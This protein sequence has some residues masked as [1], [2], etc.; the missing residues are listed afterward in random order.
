[1]KRILTILLLA[2]LLV[3]CGE[4]NKTQT[5]SG[6][7]EQN[8]K[9]DKQLRGTPEELAQSAFD[10]FVKNDKQAYKRL[11]AANL[12]EKEWVSL[13]E[14]V[15][16]SRGKLPS[17]V[18]DKSSEELAAKESKNVQEGFERSW[19]DLQDQL[20]KEGIDP[21]QAKFVKFDIKRLTAEEVK[22]MGDRGPPF[23]FADVTVIFKSNQHEYRLRVDDCMKLPGPGW[24]ANG[25]A[26]LDDH[27]HGHDHDHEHGKESG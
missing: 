5:G 2:L 6:D 16:S 19:S 22:E 10:A 26:F 1:M 20:K 14:E 24:T 3:G 15:Q 8:A 4:S 13:I 21:S 25:A 7:N 18:A 23:E 12:S 9:S 11:T 17:N 27:D